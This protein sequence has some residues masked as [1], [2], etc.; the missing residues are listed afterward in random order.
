MPYT[1]FGC[2]VCTRIK[3][4]ALRLWLRLCL[5][6]VSSAP[7]GKDNSF[8]AMLAAAICYAKDKPMQC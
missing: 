6:G 1:K 4:N 2:V 3:T 8:A 7:I 5:N